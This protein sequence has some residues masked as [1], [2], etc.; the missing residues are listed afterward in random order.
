MTMN[1]DQLRR[2]IVGVLKDIHGTIPYS[3]SAVELLMLTSAT[4]SNLGTYVMQVKGPARGIF[5]MEPNT[6]KDIINNYAKNKPEIMALINRYKSNSGETDLIGNIPY[7]IL[8]AR[9]LYR[10]SPKVLPSTPHVET[11]ASIWK[12]VYNTRLGKGTVEKAVE[13]YKEYC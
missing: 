10:R 13:K 6:E 5:Q 4:E 9:L 12:E 11:L 3:D 7:Q 2:L 8:M 1:K